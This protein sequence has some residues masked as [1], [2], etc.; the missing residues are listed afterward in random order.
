VTKLDDAQYAGLSL[1]V[2]STQTG[3]LTLETNSDVTGE[4]AQCLADADSWYEITFDPLPA[5]KPNKYHRIE[6]RVDQP[7]LV[8]R[9]RDGYYANPQILAPQH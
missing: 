4:I 5:D 3:G 8:V 7:G 9:T 2:L 1:Q 6:V